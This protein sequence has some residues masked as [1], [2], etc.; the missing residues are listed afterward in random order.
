M[1]PSNLI[2]ETKCAL[3]EY[4]IGFPAVH[5]VWFVAL[6]LQEV[7]HIQNLRLHLGQGH[8]EP[9]QKLSNYSFSI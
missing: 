4:K 3:P 6:H 1:S 7:Q 5:K 9:K 8:L 2:T